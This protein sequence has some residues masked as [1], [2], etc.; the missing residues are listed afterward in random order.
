MFYLYKNNSFIPELPETGYLNRNDFNS[1]VELKKLSY[2]TNIVGQFKTRAEIKHEYD[3]ERAYKQDYQAYMA[4]YRE[5]LQC[6]KD[7]VE[8]ILWEKRMRATK[9]NVAQ[10]EFMVDRN[11]VGRFPKPPIEPN[12]D[13][14]KATSYFENRKMIPRVELQIMRLCN[15]V[16]DDE[17][18]VGFIIVLPEKVDPRTVTRYKRAIEMID[19]IK[20]VEHERLLIC[21]DKRQRKGDY[22]PFLTSIKQKYVHII[23][24]IDVDYEMFKNLK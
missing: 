9:A 20:W 12:P 2:N 3:L 15:A 19:N 24:R 22:R 8:A 11:L 21:Y 17:E 6:R 5:W 7:Y 13:N 16:V 23:S 14:Y 1:E 4:L 18:R 10:V